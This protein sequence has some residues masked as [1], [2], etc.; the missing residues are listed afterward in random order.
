MGFFG[1]LWNGITGIG[2]GVIG[3]I[4]G[5]GGAIVGGIEGVFGGGGSQAGAVNNTPYVNQPAPITNIYV[6]PLPAPA[7]AQGP[8]LTMIIII[9]VVFF[10][11][12]F[13]L[14]K[15]GLKI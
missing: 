6:P 12:M 8:D 3:S 2:K 14:T 10:G 5:V 4:P 1:S 11:I 9:A 7:P 13:V 15:K